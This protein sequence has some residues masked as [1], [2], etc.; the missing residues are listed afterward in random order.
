MGQG[1]WARQEFLTDAWG[2]RCKES[3]PFQDGQDEPID[4]CEPIANS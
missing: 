1:F 2:V 3:Y 4:A